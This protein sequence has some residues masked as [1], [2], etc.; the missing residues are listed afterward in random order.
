MKSPGRITVTKKYN[1]LDIICYHVGGCGDYSHLNIIGSKYPERTVYVAFE[2][3]D[4]EDDDQVKQEYLDKGIR[5]I[6][7]K[8]CVYDTDGMVKFNVNVEPASSSIFNASPSAMTEHMP[9]QPTMPMWGSHATPERVVEL[10]MSS[11]DKLISEN[12]LPLP[13]ILSI[14]AQ[15]AEYMILKGASNTLSQGVM[16]VITEVEFHQIYEGQPLFSHQFDLL[17]TDGFR[18]VDIL[19]MQYWHPLARVGHGMLTV[20][21]ALFMRFDEQYLQKLSVYG[22]IK[23]AAI[24][25]AFKR[26]SISVYVMNIAFEK[27]GSLVENIINDNYDFQELLG[28]RDYVMANMDKYGKDAFFFENDAKICKIYGKVENLKNKSLP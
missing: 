5:T 27:Y 3:R 14:D 18:L 23:F 28:L 19:A 8:K 20:G 10:E 26:L 6:L 9:D 17:Y 24:S 4:S 11:I 1:E 13:D 15:G 25:L 22:L 21:E 12:D 7:I 2:A 16:S